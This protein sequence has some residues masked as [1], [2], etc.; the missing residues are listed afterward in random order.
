MNTPPLYQK[1]LNQFDL[2]D[3]LQARIQQDDSDAGLYFRTLVNIESMFDT[4]A[5]GLVRQSA[6]EEGKSD[7]E[8]SELMKMANTK[9]AELRITIRK[10][11]QAHDFDGVLKDMGEQAYKDWHKL[12]A[13]HPNAASWR[14]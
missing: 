6:I 11:S 3:E 8:A 4:Y 7:D 12:P 14:E 1:L 5:R 13:D 9:L 2:A 10:L